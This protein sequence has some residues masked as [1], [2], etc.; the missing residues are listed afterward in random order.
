M[1]ENGENSTTAEKE[2]DLFN[3]SARGVPV[4]VEGY[5]SLGDP[6]CEKWHLGAGY[7]G[8]NGADHTAHPIRGSHGIQ[9]SH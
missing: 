1:K 8:A 6:E 5:Q 7:K 2:S 9:S 3:F 4:H